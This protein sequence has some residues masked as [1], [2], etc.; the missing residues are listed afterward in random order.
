MELVQKFKVAIAWYQP[1]TDTDDWINF[2][3]YVY[4][5]DYIN[6][7]GATLRQAATN[8]VSMSPGLDIFM[9]ETM[10]GKMKNF[11]ILG[12][13]DSSIQNE[14]VKCFINSDWGNASHNNDLWHS[15]NDAAVN[16]LVG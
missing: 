16:T 5:I 14:Y 6:A 9:W 8:I 11:L 13:P 3:N 10:I 7:T 12:P 1:T 15:I 2:N 4:S